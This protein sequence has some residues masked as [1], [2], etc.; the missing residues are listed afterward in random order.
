MLQPRPSAS[1][2]AQE[3]EHLRADSKDL[4]SNSA[5]H[6]WIALKIFYINLVFSGT[7]SIQVWD[8]LV[9][10]TFVLH[11]RDVT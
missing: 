8:L 2:L 4:G 10:S 5:V 9:D 11:V 3:V 1:A 6:F 7:L